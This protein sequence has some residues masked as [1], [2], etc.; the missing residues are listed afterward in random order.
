MVRVDRAFFVTAIYLLFACGIGSALADRYPSRPVRIIVPSAAGGVLD[1]FARKMAD[2]LSRSL[3]QPFIVDNRPG[4]LGTIAADLAARSKPDGYTLLLGN[5]S[6]LCIN[7]AL[8][9]TLPYDPVRSFSPIT[10][11]TR[12]NPVLLTN[13]EIPVQ[14]LSDLIAYAK[15][16]P[17]ELNFGSPGNGSVQHL[18]GELFS[19]LAGVKITH[20]PYKNQAQVITDLMA[21]VIQIDIEF[22][23]IAV[24]AV[25]SGKVRALVV[26]GR[27]RKPALPDVPS[28]A[29]VGLPEFEV[30][31]WNGYLVPAGTR[32][33]IIAT[34]HKEITGALKG[35]EFAAWLASMD[36]ETVA[37]TPQQ[38]ASVIQTELV[39]WRRIVE[40]SG[41]SAE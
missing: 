39:R 38:F 17:G 9:K 22:A 32:P 21:G 6:T 5:S 2:Q 7:P 19:R 16:R 3:G 10:L 14:N 18:A 28:A 27:N 25:K 8:H 34:L 41:V 30:I 11:G 36:S 23:A 29:E 1:V 12:G 33:D 4:A 20:V 13:S 31:A 40:E 15:A 37:S 24:P 35:K 26:A